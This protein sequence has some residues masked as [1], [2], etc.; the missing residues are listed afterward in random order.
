MFNKINITDFRI[1]LGLI[2]LSILIFFTPGA[3]ALAPKIQ[4]LYDY[5]NDNHAVSLVDGTDGEIVCRNGDPLGIFDDPQI[6]QLWDALSRE[7]QQRVVD[8]DHCQELYGDMGQTIVDNCRELVDPSTGIVKDPIDVGSNT[9][10]PTAANPN[11]GTS[12]DAATGRFECTGDACV[13]DNPI[14]EFLFVVINILSGLIGI[15]V[16]IVIIMAGIQ[17]TTSGGNPQQAAQA[18]KR[19]INAITA[20]VA[21]FFLFAILQWLIPGGIFKS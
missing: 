18:K 1:F 17:Y 4:Q 19:I 3:N 14:T 21:F 13:N 2:F 6:T 5:C 11:G 10:A 8:T 9:D 7:Q 15:I 16:V 12:G 20:L